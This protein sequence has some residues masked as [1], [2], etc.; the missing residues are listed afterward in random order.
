MSPSHIV[1]PSAGNNPTTQPSKT[2][3]QKKFTVISL[4]AVAAAATLLILAGEIPEIEEWKNRNTTMKEYNQDTI[5]TAI[6]AGLKTYKYN[7]RAGDSYFF[8]LVPHKTHKIYICSYADD[9]EDS[10][11]TTDLE[12][13]GSPVNRHI[14]EAF[15]K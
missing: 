15:T 9:F 8:S 10:W 6:L 1:H 4:A 5:E 13:F 14:S 3:T 7:T 2:M 12:G 11:M